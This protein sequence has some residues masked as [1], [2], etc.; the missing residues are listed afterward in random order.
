MPSHDWYLQNV[1]YPSQIEDPSKLAHQ[2]G[3][4]LGGLADLVSVLPH[5]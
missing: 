1:V 5:E 2:L 3:R 4:W